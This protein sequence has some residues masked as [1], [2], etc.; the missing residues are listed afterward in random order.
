[1]REQGLLVVYTPYAE[2]IHHES[3][4]RGYSATAQEA[5]RFQQ[6]K[7]Q[8]RQRWLP[9]LQQGDPYYNPNLALDRGYYS[10]RFPPGS[11][12]PRAMPGLLRQTPPEEP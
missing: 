6:E 4:S 1:M 12:E 9:L 11:Q 5:A 7:Q 2:L 10:L 3:L 8:F